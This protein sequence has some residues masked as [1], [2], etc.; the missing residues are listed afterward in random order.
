MKSKMTTNSQLSTTKPKKQ[1]QKQKQTKQ[2]TRTGTESQ[3]WTSHGGLSVEKG[4]MG[5]KVQGM[6]SINGRQKIER[7]RLSIVW[8]MEK[9]KNLYV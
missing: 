2:T 7:G 9:P 5:E 6:S 8:E 4:R 1:K 3:K